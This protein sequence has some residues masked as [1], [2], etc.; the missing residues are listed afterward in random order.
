M[1]LLEDYKIIYP[2]G[3]T[4]NYGDIHIKKGMLTGLFGRSGCGKTSLLES[5][6]NPEFPG[7]VT[8]KRALLD[9]KPYPPIGP[10]LYRKI[11]YCPQFSQAALNPKL[12]IREHLRLTLKGNGITEDSEQIKE[13]LDRL[14][15]KESMLDRR[16]GGLSGGQ[17]QRMVLLLCAVKKP[18]LMILDEPSSAIDLITLKEIADFLETLKGDTTILMVAHSRALLDRVADHV[19][20]L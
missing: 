17:Q 18:K 10:D 5:L 4:L 6:L 9:Q 13:L 11:S 16:P 15:L 7:Y 2:D 12:T 20:D 3:K 8:Y 19:I 1:L 14:C